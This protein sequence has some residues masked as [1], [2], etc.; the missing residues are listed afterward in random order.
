MDLNPQ[1]DVLEDSESI[2][3]EIDQLKG[4]KTKVET[5]QFPEHIY[6]LLP[7]FLKDTCAFFDQGR[8]RDVFLAS[9]LAVLSGCMPG[10]QFQHDGKT[11]KTNLFLFVIAPAASGKGK[12]NYG[13]DLAQPIQRKYIKENDLKKEAYQTEMA[14][15]R[16]TPAKERLYLDEPMEPDYQYL[17]IPANSSSASFVETMARIPS[18]ILFESEA[19]TLG[20]TLKQDWS[21]YSDVLRKAFEHETH[22]QNRKGSG[23]YKEIE[24]PCLSVALSGTPGQLKGIIP[25]TEDGLFSRFMFY[26]FDGDEKFRNVF[27][28]KSKRIPYRDQLEPYSRE[29][30]SLY[31]KCQ[32]WESVQ[33]SWRPEQEDKL[34]EKYEKWTAYYVRTYGS[35]VKSI[36]FRS[37]IIVTRIAA[38]LTV[39]RTWENQDYSNRDQVCS[40]K[41]FD[42]AIALTETFIEHSM[43][44]HS[45]LLKK[46][47]TE[48]FPLKKKKFYESLPNV[49][50]RRVADSIGEELNVQQR[51]VTNYLKEFVGS[52]L[53]EKLEHGQYKKLP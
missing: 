9:A 18:S 6:R 53:L 50:E 44:M 25:N 31:E 48:S 41:D 1:H 16:A 13:K 21:G 33:F 7:K 8:D 10:V 24:D 34:Q 46:D 15:F 22:S 42:T 12:M 45:R 26:C 38:I 47:P 40:G 37:A 5:P 52:G 3:K 2:T 30:L 32:S 39:L 4:V 43:Y 36:I 27:G 19:D 29:L 20:N 49:F 51:T 11:Y 23:N 28:S 17:F 35:D 14:R